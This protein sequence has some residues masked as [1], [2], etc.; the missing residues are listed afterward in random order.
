MVAYKAY[1]KKKEGLDYVHMNY[2]F[3]SPTVDI[4]RSEK[5]LFI[6]LNVTSCEEF[7]C[8]SNKGHLNATSDSQKFVTDHSQMR[9]YCQYCYRADYNRFHDR[10]LAGNCTAYTFPK[11]S[12]CK[13][14]SSGYPLIFSLLVKRWHSP[15]IC[16]C[17]P[18]DRYGY[19]CDAYSIGFAPFMLN[20]VP[21]FLVI[22]STVI[23]IILQTFWV[24]PFL[25][26]RTK[27]LIRNMDEF[28]S[29]FKQFFE[30]RFVI[31]LFM[32]ANLTF[33]AFEN[34]FSISN[35]KLYLA[36]R[37]SFGDGFFRS[38]A[39]INLLFSM[40]TLFTVWVKVLHQA[41]SLNTSG[42]PIALA[43]VLGGIYLFFFGLM[44]FPFANVSEQVRKKGVLNQAFFPLT[45]V[46]MILFAAGFLIYGLRLYYRVAKSQKLTVFQLKFTRFMIVLVFLLLT[47]AI[48]MLFVIIEFLAPTVQFGLSYRLFNFPLLDVTFL[49]VVLAMMYQIYNHDITLQAYS[50][51]APVFKYISYAYWAERREIY[52]TRR[53]AE[54]TTNYVQINDSGK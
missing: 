34:F 32:T 43:A 29:K 37:N 11:R 15:Y 46:S 48:Q 9:N 20:F 53:E 49:C 25:I 5:D 51:L 28:S 36:R 7:F 17:I 30:L 2:F 52:R 38:L 50:K 18:R 6:R 35:T 3:D 22:V 4:C 12:V 39:F 24:V 21:I 44:A 1:N 19:K 26:V 14:A 23:L 54:Y 45:L 10:V 27:D 16:H 33:C 40:F 47:I 8:D 42:I 13:K 31:M 41:D